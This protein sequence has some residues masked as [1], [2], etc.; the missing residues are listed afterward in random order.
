MI[1]DSGQSIPET[2]GAN[3]EAEKEVVVLSTAHT[4][5]AVLAL[6]MA[7]GSIPADPAADVNLDGGVTSLDA[8][9]ILQVAAGVN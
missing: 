5:D 3:N 6:Q 1:V 4:V 2:D 8:L 9:M 7:A